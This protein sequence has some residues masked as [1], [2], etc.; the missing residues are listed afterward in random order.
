M[1]TGESE[2]G[3]QRA[4]VPGAEL[5]VTPGVTVPRALALS[6]PW[7]RFALSFCFSADAL[8]KS[9][10]TA[11][12]LAVTCLVCWRQSLE[13]PAADVG[14]PVAL[15]AAL[16]ALGHYYRR[17][18][19]DSF[20]LCLTALAQIVAFATCYV[21]AMYALATPTWPLVDRQLAAFDAWCGVHVPWLCRW[22]AD[23]PAGGLLLRAAY[24]SLLYQTAAVIVLLGLR[25]QRR[26]LEGFV[27]AFML[28]ALIAL[29]IFVVMPACG[30]FAEYGLTPS[31]DQS[32][33]LDHF[34]SLRDGS[35]Q[36]ISYRGAEGLITFPS[37]HV[38]WALVIVWALRGSRPVFAAFA[39]LNALLILSTMTTGWHYFADLLGGAAVA[40]LAIVGTNALSRAGSLVNKR[41]KE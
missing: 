27:L 18:G 23:H 34:L 30:P 24:D 38:A 7:P 14:P 6:A 36:V 37:F 19:E 35:R 17:R 25:N 32:I 33:F 8:L 11:L 2:S 16:I 29:A 20:V 4:R 3:Q 39:V 13:V 28:A 1:Q 9:A 5:A 26:P 15:V 10:L 41:A 40:I 12:L 31:H 21:V 22:A